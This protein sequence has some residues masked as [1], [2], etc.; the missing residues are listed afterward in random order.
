MRKILIPTMALLLAGCVN[1]SASYY[2]DDRD[3]ALTVLR[4][5]RYFWS[6]DATV[7]LVVAR[8]P[9]C[10]RRRE[11]TLA[12][13]SSVHIDVFA[14]PDATWTLRSDTML[15]RVDTGTCTIST[16]TPADALGTRVGSFKVLDQRL[17]FAIDSAD[18]APAR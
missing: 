17:R 5:Q 14:N 4:A 12:P 10:Q 6:D 7:T 11:L 8:L 13:V 9:D 18:A 3:H 2:I 16:A 15:W 1:D